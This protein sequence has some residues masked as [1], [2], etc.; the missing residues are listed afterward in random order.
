MIN[1]EILRSYNTH[2]G[3]KVPRTYGNV[4]CLNKRDGIPLWG[5]ATAQELTQIADLSFAI[6][7]PKDF[8]ER[9]SK[10]K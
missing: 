9:K 4:F 6:K 8:K 1:K 10:L 7:D 3:F 5:D 2:P